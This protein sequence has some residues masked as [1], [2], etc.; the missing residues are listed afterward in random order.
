MPYRYAH[1]VIL[2][3]LVPAIAVAFWPQYLGVL[4]AAPFALHAHG[5]TASLWVLLIV[6]QSWTVHNRRFVWHRAAARATLVLVPLF[7]GG[8]GLVV[9]SMA[10]KYVNRS[11]PFSAT[12]G[13]R[14]GVDDILTT[15]LMVWMVRRAIV[16]RRRVGVHAAY[17]L[18]TVLLLLPP[19]IVRLPIPLPVPFVSSFA[20]SLVVAL[21]LYA[22][23]RRDGGPFLIT[24]GYTVVRV[25]LL[26]TFSAS[27]VWARTFARI[28]DVPAVVIG[29]LC[30]AAGVAA[31][32]T[33]WPWPVRRVAS[34][35][36]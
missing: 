34:A 7:A 1:Y 29:P 10:I 18:S 5:I 15:I 14:L 9:H 16:N 19:V 20:I 25:I 24:A 13:A 11:D 6:V 35:A 8:A 2:F 30:I 33:V 27:E 3:V 28:A 31:I 32:W 4:P 23:R 12:L 22:I 36:V 21:A 17:M 26:S